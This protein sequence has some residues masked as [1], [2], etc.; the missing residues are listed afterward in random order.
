MVRLLLILEL[1]I[2]IVALIFCIGCLYFS[3]KFKKEEK[4]KQSMNKTHF[5]PH[6]KNQD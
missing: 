6:K 4:R 5:K 2:I 1:M 3:Y